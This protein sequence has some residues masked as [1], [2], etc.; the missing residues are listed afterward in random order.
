[1]MTLFQRTT[2]PYQKVRKP[3]MLIPANLPLTPCL[4]KVQQSPDPLRKFMECGG[5]RSATSLWSNGQDRVNKS[6]VAASLCRRTPY[7]VHIRS[8]L[9]RL[10]GDN[11]HR[12]FTETLMSG[13]SASN[14]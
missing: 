4:S 6:T 3:E 12:M 2:A 13:N 5:K 14:S 7:C 9:D 11:N 1:M 8:S 10:A